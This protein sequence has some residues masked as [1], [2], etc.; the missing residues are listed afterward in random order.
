MNEVL[1]RAALAAAILVAVVALALA[2]R[3]LVR[4]RAQRVLAAPHDPSLATGAV[5]VL[6]FH[7]DHCGDCLVQE[8]EL[9]RLLID[10]PDL[11]I[12]ADHAPS[13]LSARFGVLAVPSTV[14]LG[15][16]GKVEAVNYG[17]VRRERLAEQVQS[18]DDEQVGSRQ[19]H[20]S[21]I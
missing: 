2:A 1:A 19:L 9:D 6:Y 20:H 15:P 13:A 4:R 5:T 8:Q 14:I 21:R 10:R 7:G 18:A 16:D 3:A 17:L 12:R 11:A